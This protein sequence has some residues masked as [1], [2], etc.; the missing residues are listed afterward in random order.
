MV[1]PCAPCPVLQDVGRALDMSSPSQPHIGKTPVDW[2]DR[3][4]EHGHRISIQ[5]LF[6]FSGAS[7]L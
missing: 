2:A 5:G 7:F 4:F 3:L 6:S 1:C